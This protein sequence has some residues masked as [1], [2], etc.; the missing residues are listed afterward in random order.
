M[1]KWVANLFRSKKPT[2]NAPRHISTVDKSYMDNLVKFNFRVTG[3][4]VWTPPLREERLNSLA[5][6]TLGPGKIVAYGD[7]NYRPI[8]GTAFVAYYRDY[9]VEKVK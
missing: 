1:F 2:P 5:N 3:K 8:E 9:Y 7:I 6:E 4:L